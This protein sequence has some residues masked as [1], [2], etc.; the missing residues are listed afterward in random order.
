MNWDD[1]IRND[2]EIV[3]LPAG[4]YD[5]EITKFEKGWFEGSS[6][7][8]PCPKAMLELTIMGSGGKAI[9]KENLLLS[10]KV[11]WKLCAFFRCLGFKQHGK[12]YQMD[13]D[14]VLGATGKAEIEINEFEGQNG[15]IRRNNK[16]KTYLDKQEEGEEALPW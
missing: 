8:D 15:E 11:E 16:V 2:N 5:F 4:I 7:I 3:L 10:E 1:F 9:V 12:E 14:K 13:W 6:K